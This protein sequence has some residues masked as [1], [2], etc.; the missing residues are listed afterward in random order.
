MSLSI[1]SQSISIKYVETKALDTLNKPHFSVV[2]FLAK[3]TLGRCTHYTIIP[4]FQEEAQSYKGL[5]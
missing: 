1:C 2:F 4:N 3:S 5:C